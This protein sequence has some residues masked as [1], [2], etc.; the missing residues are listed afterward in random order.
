VQFKDANDKSLPI[1][2]FPDDYPAFESRK[3]S[4]ATLT[5]SQNL[6]F[7]SL[8]SITGYEEGR[9]VSAQDSDLTPA[10]LFEFNSDQRSSQFSEELRLVSLGDSRFS[11]IAG[12]LYFREGASVYLPFQISIANVGVLFDAH[13]KTDSY[14]GFLEGTYKITDRLSVT[15][16]G[17]YNE[18]QK[19][20]Q[21][22]VASF[23]STTV[24]TPGLCS[25]AATQ[26]D[27]RSWGSFTPRFVLNYQLSKDLL[28]YTSA[29]RGFR[30][31]GWNFTD[32][33]SIHSGFNP[34]NIWSYEGG[35]KSESFDHRLRVNVAGFYANYSD[36]QVRINDGPFLATRN[37]GAAR[38]Y[39]TELESEVRP[40]DHLD[41]TATA[42]WL[43]AKYTQ[44]STTS[45]GLT[46][47]YAGS[48]LNRAPEF[49]ATLAAQYAI[50]A[51][52]VGIFT[53]RVEYHHVSQVFYSQDNVQPQG[54]D[55]YNEV[56]LRVRYE[57]PVGHWNVMAFVNNL[58]NNQFRTHTF[59]GN[60]PGQVAATY[61]TPRIFGL[62]GQYNW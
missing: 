35:V 31:G 4:A 55:P 17:R 47:D 38:I 49:S 13:L 8:V 24:V 6:G 18:D 48:F 9:A 30:S 56:N 10:Y 37:A 28:L 46:Q 45:N 12:F 20:W 16:G 53:P 58:S 27:S 21:G 43:D 50:E 29:T 44:F 39:G 62:Q 1:D 41:L 3:Y 2:I 14:S 36:L 33:T 40:I 22:C 61:S 11:W 26:P 7:A 32:A 57:P 34:E 60:L 42:S 25:G 52:G 59:P 19:H 5:A 51:A 54:A 23:T 15:A